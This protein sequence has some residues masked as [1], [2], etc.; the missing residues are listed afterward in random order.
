MHEPH[1]ESLTPVRRDAVIAWLA[2]EV[3]ICGSCGSPVLVSQPRRLGKTGVEHSACEQAPSVTEPLAAAEPLEE[4]SAAV[5][6]RARRS[7]WG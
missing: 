5:A 2:T 4:T 3:G 6:A 1:L 7:D